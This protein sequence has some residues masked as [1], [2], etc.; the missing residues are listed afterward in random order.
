M[1]QSCNSQAIST[2]IIWE[3]SEVPSRSGEC[4]KNAGE[5]Q[6]SKQES[7]NEDK[8]PDVWPIKAMALGTQKVNF[9]SK[10]PLYCH[11]ASDKCSASGEGGRDISEGPPS[12]QALPGGHLRLQSKGTAAR[13]L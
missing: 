3:G 1:T 12:R 4:L 5:L 7:L 10:S 6:I 11:C 13:G 2:H 9:I 8:K